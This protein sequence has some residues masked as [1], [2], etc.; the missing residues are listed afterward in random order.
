M[1]RKEESDFIRVSVVYD[2]K[3]RLPV[4]YIKE[5]ARRGTPSDGSGER[6]RAA[7]GRGYGVF[8]AAAFG[9]YW[10]ITGWIASAQIW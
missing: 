7:T 3:E 2:D 4:R 8:G 9:K 10:S 1:Q 5:P 6:P